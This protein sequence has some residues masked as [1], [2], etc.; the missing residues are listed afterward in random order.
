MNR[1][2]LSVIWN[3]KHWF[4]GVIGNVRLG[5]LRDHKRSLLSS[6]INMEV[7]LGYRFNL[8]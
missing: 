8:W 2:E 1:G 7:S 5:M 6:V 3:N 4:A